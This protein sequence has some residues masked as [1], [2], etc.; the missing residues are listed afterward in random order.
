[1]DGMMQP[2]E[3]LDPEEIAVFAYCIWEHEGRPDGRA[4]DHWLEAERQLM[5]TRQETASNYF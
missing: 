3:P 4:L 2:S 5:A 1:M